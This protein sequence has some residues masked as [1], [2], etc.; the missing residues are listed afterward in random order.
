MK[1]YSTSVV[2]SVVSGAPLPI[3]KATFVGGGSLTGSYVVCCHIVR[4][5]VGCTVVSGRVTLPALSVRSN[6]GI[7]RSQSIKVNQSQFNNL[8]LVPFHSESIHCWGSWNNVLVL[9]SREGKAGPETG[10]MAVCPY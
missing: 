10:E 2:S 4:G 7:C 5:L 8:T 3:P 1:V 9:P 6:T